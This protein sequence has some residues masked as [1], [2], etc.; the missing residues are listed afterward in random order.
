MKALHTLDGA[1]KAR[2]LHDL[3]PHEMPALLDAINAFCADFAERKEEYRASWK[4]GFMPF[5]YWF[6]LS[7]ETAELIKKYG[8]NLKRSSKVFSDQLY[9]TYTAM[10]V[11]DRIAKYAE[12]TS[13][14]EKF[15]LMVR[16]LFS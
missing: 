13:T 4:D 16:V 11:T 15:K 12:N 1:A 2:L 3:F 8:F 14:D 9:F 10:F 5:D 7:K 6:S